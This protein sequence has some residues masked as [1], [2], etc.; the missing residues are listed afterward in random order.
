MAT[1]RFMA[2]SIKEQ[3]KQQF[4]DESVTIDQIV[5]WILLIS[6]R[7]RYDKIKRMDGS[8]AYLVYF[9][10]I[11]IFT[12]DTSKRKYCVL[13]ETVVNLA[14]DYGI[15][16]VAYCH[17]DSHLCEEPLARPF[18]RA[19]PKKVSTLY[20]NPHR[21]PS[22]SN[23]YF[24]RSVML[25]SGVNTEVLIFLGLECV[26]LNCIDMW[27][28]SSES[29]EYVCDLDTEINISPEMEKIIYYE[30]LNLAR[31]GFMTPQ[32]FKNDGSDTQFE[33]K[34]QRSQQIAPLYADSGESQPTQQPTQ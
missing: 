34:T 19:T 6:K 28:Y 12:D 29:T 27:L 22:S 33:D 23:V 20:G 16:T 15:E 31:Y 3:I 13:P 10:E 17:K 14:N 7:A 11:T 8:G 1:Y 4:D 9:P 18:N 32:D 30:V 21:A 24:F 2:N 5:Y 25:I 26:D